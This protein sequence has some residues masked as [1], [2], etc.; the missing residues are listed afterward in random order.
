MNA[1]EKSWLSLPHLQS[2]RRQQ[3]SARL[4]EL[5]LVTRA[6][7]ARLQQLRCPVQIFRCCH[8][9][10]LQAIARVNRPYEEEA[11]LSKP[12]GLVVDFVGVFESLTK[13]LAFDSD[14]VSSVIQNVDVKSY[15]DPVAIKDALVRQLC[16][17]VRWIE[18]ITAL[19]DAGMKHVVECGPGKVLVGLNKRIDARIRALA[20]CDQAS[21]EA[22]KSILQG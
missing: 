19:A 9:T 17:P 16:G 11:E 15:S 12:V 20:I 14:E 2:K 13:A 7:E 5:D 21:I 1:V 10:L 8:H 6:R 4:R 22:I 18:T 3:A